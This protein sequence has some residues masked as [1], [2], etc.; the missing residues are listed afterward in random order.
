MGETAL[1]WAAADDHADAVRALAKHGAEINVRS[2]TVAYPPQKPKDPSNYVT[3]FVPKGQWTPLMY[4]AREGAAGAAMALVALGPTS[5]CGTR[6]ASHPCSKPFSTPTSTWRRC[7]S[8]R[9][10]IP[11]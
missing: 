8:T 11:T 10:P 2:T 1:M 5:T 7:C 3:S 9:A 4:A 6:R